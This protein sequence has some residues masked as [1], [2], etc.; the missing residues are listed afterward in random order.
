M[1]IALHTLAVVIA[2]GMSATAHAASEDVPVMDTDKFFFTQAPASVFGTSERERPQAVNG[3]L[4]AVVAPLYVTPPFLSYLRLFNGGGTTAT[5]TVT[6]VGSGTATAYGTAT[7]NVPTAATLQLS[8]STVL[9]AA[10]AVNRHEDDAQ[11]SFYIQSAAPLAGYQHVT[12]NEDAH[13]FENAAVCKW[14]IQEVISKASNQ[15]VLPSIHTSRLAA[16][17][18]P[19]QIE[20]HNYANAPITYRFFVRDETTGAL[21]GQMDFPARANAS[22]TIPWTQVESTIGW[23]PMENQIRANLIVTDTSGAPPALVLGQTIVNESAQVSINM[24]SMCA[25]NEPTSS[26]DPGGELPGGGISY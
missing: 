10:N 7:Y 9:I 13:Y 8:M 23:N 16:V 25:V 15:M 18:Y 6:V 2:V 26:G 22:Y 21:V 24:T 11:F 19:S 17:G 14:T 4:Y 12:L 3:A 5:F 20:L 1:R